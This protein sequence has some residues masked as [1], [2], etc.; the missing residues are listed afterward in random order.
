MPDQYLPLLTE[1][2]NNVAGNDKATYFKSVNI[3]LSSYY[4][5]HIANQ[6]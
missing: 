5:F 4:V 6:F 3:W 1:D 2:I